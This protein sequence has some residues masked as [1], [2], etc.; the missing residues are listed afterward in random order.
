M[1]FDFCSHLAL[2]LVGILI[3]EDMTRDLPGLALGFFPQAILRATKEIGEQNSH[4]VKFVAHTVPQHHH[5]IP[6]PH[7]TIFISQIVLKLAIGMQVDIYGVV[8]YE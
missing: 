8:V 2:F 7:M 1:K 6:V 4:L 5:F 3:I